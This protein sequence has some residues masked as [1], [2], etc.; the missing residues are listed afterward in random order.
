MIGRQNFGQIFL[1]FW[2]N[3]RYHINIYRTILKRQSQPSAST[4][5]FKIVYGACLRRK[6]IKMEFTNTQKMLI[7]ILFNMKLNNSCG[8]D[9][10]NIII[11]LLQSEDISTKDKKIVLNI[12]FNS[13]I[14]DNL[15]DIY[16][17]YERLNLLEDCWNLKEQMKWVD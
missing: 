17:E 16:K 6:E 13:N 8:S 12:L 15:E 10:R 11:N 1:Y 5:L 9:N 7:G 3:F 4:I 2:S 14:L